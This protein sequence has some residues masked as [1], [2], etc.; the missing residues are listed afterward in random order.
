MEFIVYK[1][2][3]RANSTKRPTN[4]PQLKLDG[5]HKKTTSLYKPTFTVTERLVGYS[6]L[7]WEQMYYYITDIIFIRKDYYELVCELDDLATY[8]ENI[9]NTTA[10]V[11]YSASNVNY[12][13]VD[14]RLSTS[15]VPTIKTSAANL[16]TDGASNMTSGTFV[17][18]YV[19]SQPTYGASGVLHLSYD[20]C[21]GV[22]QSLVS[23]GFKGW[24]ESFPKQFNGAYDALLSCLYL[25][26]V[27]SSTADKNVVLGGYDT[28]VTGRLPGNHSYSCD[29]TIPWAFN[30]FRNL[31]PY[32][33]LML[34]LPAYGF[35]ELNP[36]DY[37]GN[38][39][40]SVELIV[41]G[42]TGTGTYLVGNN[43]KASTTFATPINIG[44]IKSNAVGATM[45]AL[46]T[47]GATAGAI[48]TSIATGGLGAPAAIGAASSIAGMAA[49]TYIASQQR[50]LG[51]VGSN[52][53]LAS[54]YLSPIAD[55]GMVQALIIAHNTVQEPSALTQTLGGTCHQALQLKTLSGYCQTINASVNTPNLTASNK[56]NSMLD[57][58]IFIE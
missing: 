24:L 35:I 52:G 42:L 16:I 27:W 57:G 58:G 50:S 29:V 10:Y 38:S 8:K 51:S 13:L 3:K 32:T 54:I 11:L 21:M 55:W 14:A 46:S 39:S 7:K 30:D 28:G 12:Q 17:I 26:F 4:E 41:D 5:W 23:D 19:T 48:A 45:S 36:C 47:V 6:Y 40:V 20:G 37:I 56:I 15:N 44:T 43:F 1:F 9:L 25:P 33:S 53:G 22:A 2:T 34:Y 31:P 18:T 49:H